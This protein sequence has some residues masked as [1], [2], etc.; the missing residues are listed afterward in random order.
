MLNQAQ[1]EGLAKVIDNI[2]TAIAVSVSV[3]LAID[4]RVTIGP[5]LFLGACSFVLLMGS[6]R[7]RKEVE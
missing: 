3:G 4:P 7:L 6:V 2:A 1:R 5:A